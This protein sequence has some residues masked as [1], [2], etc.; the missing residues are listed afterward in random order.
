MKSVG[1]VNECSMYTH[2]NLSEAY[3][4]KAQAA[5]PGPAFQRNLLLVFEHLCIACGIGIAYHG[6]SHPNTKRKLS[7]LASLLE[8]TGKDQLARAVRAATLRSQLQAVC[9]VVVG[10]LSRPLAAQQ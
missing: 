10:M 4:R 6:S 3:M 8:Q 9:S 5:G 2:G 7:E 1:E